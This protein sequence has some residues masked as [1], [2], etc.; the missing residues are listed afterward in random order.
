MAID[1]QRYRC[2]KFYD[3]LFEAPGKA[4]QAA[5]RLAEYLDDLTDAELADRRVAADLAIKTQGITFTVYS[6]GKNVDRAWPFDLIPRVIPRA[7]WERTERGLKQ[8]VTALNHFIQDIY[9]AQK[10]VKDRV[11][12]AELL[13][14]SVNFRKQCVGVTPP[15]GVWAHICGSDLVRDGDGTLYV[16]EDNLRV[17]SGVSYMMENRAVTKRVFPEL[18]ETT[19]I[20]P[21][22]DYPAQLLEMLIEMSPRRAESPTIVLLTPGI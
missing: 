14:E 20:L 4:R 22:D 13:A 2:E 6:E 1:W 8:R 7:E 12:P 18:F 5:C 17:P 16:L 15:H 10:I 3:E 11:F 9:G 19:T 21:V